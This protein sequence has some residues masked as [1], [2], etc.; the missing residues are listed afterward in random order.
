LTVGPR[1]LSVEAFPQPLLTKFIVSSALGAVTEHFKRAIHGLKL[2]F[3]S[4]VPRIF[5]RMQ[6]FRELAVSLFDCFGARV[7]SHTENAVEVF[8]HAKEEA[9]S[10]L[11]T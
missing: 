9:K 1:T 3:G 10:P 2:G 11:A 7:A 8:S 4:C 5:V 6:V